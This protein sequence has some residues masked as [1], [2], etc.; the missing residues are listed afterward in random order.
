MWPLVKIKCV[1]TKGNLSCY[2]TLLL[3]QF[4]K[5]I[6]NN[7]KFLLKMFKNFKFDVNI[8][9]RLECECISLSSPTI[10]VISI[11]L[12]KKTHQ[13]V[14]C[15][16]PASK[17]NCEFVNSTGDTA[18]NAGPSD[19]STRSCLI[20]LEKVR[21]IFRMFDLGFTATRQLVKHYIFPVAA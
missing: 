12:R 7:K 3:Y 10:F 18:L 4:F 5:H 6:E 21:H 8:F 2:K 16:C 11:I 9:E 1:I 15:Y 14:W 13:I 17:F 19:V 20:A